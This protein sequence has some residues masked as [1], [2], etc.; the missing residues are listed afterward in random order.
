MMMLSLA[1]TTKY[2]QLILS[3]GVGVGIGSGFLLVPALSIQSHH[4]RRKRS[5][6]M[7]LVLSG[8]YPPPRSPISVP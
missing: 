6:I 1:D 3:Q 4:W 2:Y 5:L 7:G 8:P